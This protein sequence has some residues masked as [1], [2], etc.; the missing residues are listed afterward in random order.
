[1]AAV[2]KIPPH[3]LKKKKRLTEWEDKR[4][5]PVFITREKRHWTSKKKV[6]DRCRNNKMS[7]VLK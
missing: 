3:K 4:D 7:Q 1:M 2:P 6:G 5:L